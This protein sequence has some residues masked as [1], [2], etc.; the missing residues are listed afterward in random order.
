MNLYHDIFTKA[1]TQYSKENELLNNFI[2]KIIK[3]EPTNERP[4][5]NL[6][7][8]AFGFKYCSYLVI[9]MGNKT[10]AQSDPEEIKSLF[11]K[12]DSSST[13][14]QYGFRIIALTTKDKNGKFDIMITS[15]TGDYSR[16]TYG[17]I[18]SLIKQF[19]CSNN[20]TEMN[21][22]ALHYYN[23]FLSKLLVFFENENKRI[24]INSDLLFVLSN[25][26]N[27]FEVKMIDFHKVFDCSQYNQKKDDGYIFGLKNLI[28]IFYFISNPSNSQPSS[29]LAGGHSNFVFNLDG[30]IDKQTIKEEGI[31]INFLLENASSNKYHLENEQIKR[32]TP[33]Y[34]KVYEKEGKTFLKMENISFGFTHSSILDIKM[35]TKTYGHDYPDRK[36]VV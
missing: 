28:K 20:K 35:G 36:S 1:N 25:M 2:P 15:H 14:S 30:T 22:N 21:M 11:S 10:Y 13:T 34:H 8:L 19:L 18:P 31:F 16:I 23:E 12:I 27:K 29:E 9:K 6:I 33:Q 26:N 32:F 7:D 3:V 5:I 17:H 24:F 4:Y